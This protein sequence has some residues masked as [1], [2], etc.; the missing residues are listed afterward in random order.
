MA[1]VGVALALAGC[2]RLGIGDDDNRVEIAWSG[3]LPNGGMNWTGVPA[4]L[5]GR[6][7]AE[8]GTGLRAW[9]LETGEVLWTRPLRTAV[10]LNRSTGTEPWRFVTPND[11][12]DV[13]GAPRVADRLL[14]ASDVYGGSFFALDRF[15]GGEIWR[16][17][18]DGFGPNRAPLVRGTTAYVGANNRSVYAVE[19]ATER[20]R[21]RTDAGGSVAGF[22]LC[23]DLVLA[24]TTELRGLERSSGDEAGALF[25]N[26]NEFLWS[27]FGAENSWAFVVGS[28][29]VYG[30]RC[31]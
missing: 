22:T 30:L 20:I 6:V 7:I 18:T 15:T 27:D 25:V 21:W 4:V 3:D 8:Y 1:A 26:E 24:N 31:S 28:E 9:N 2:E 5:D 29:A 19:A 23:G 17:R 12:S 14:L 16:I 11:R 13:S 10:A